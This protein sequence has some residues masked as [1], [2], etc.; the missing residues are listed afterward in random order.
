[1][2][3]NNLHDI[4][5]DFSQLHICRK[6]LF[7]YILIH[8]HKKSRLKA[9]VIAHNISV[10][11]VQPPLLHTHTR[12]RQ[13]GQSHLPKKKQRITPAPPDNYT[14]QPKSPRTYPH[15]YVPSYLSFSLSPCTVSL[16]YTQNPF[17]LPCVALVSLRGA[18]SASCSQSSATRRR[19]TTTQTYR[20]P[21]SQ[22]RTYI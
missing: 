7:I 18:R 11:I 8:T 15:T 12:T 2:L 9:S 16:S 4:A 22:R 19:T 3:S 1:M 6:H 21:I 5:S 17:L 10:L 14:R 13:E 20:K